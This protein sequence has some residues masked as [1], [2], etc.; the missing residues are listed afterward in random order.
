[1]EMSSR[2]RTVPVPHEIAEMLSASSGRVFPFSYN[3]M[4]MAFRKAS[5]KLGFDVSAHILRHTYATRLEEAG[6]PPK[7]KQYLMGHA[8]VHMTEDVYTD[9]QAHY[10]NSLSDRVRGLFDT[11]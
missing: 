11:K 8:T 7:I 6:I 10:V 9:A 3:A 4:R 5:K 1:M 2:F